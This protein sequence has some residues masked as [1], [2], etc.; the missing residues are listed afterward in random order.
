MYSENTNYQ[1]ELLDYVKSFPIFDAYNGKTL[2]ITGAAGLIGTYIVDLLMKKNEIDG[3]CITV[4]AIDR[5][6][7]EINSR[8]GMYF[9]DPNFKY[10]VLDVTQPMPNDLPRADY[11]IHAASNTSP[12]DYGLHPVDT[13]KANTVGT[14]YMLEFAHKKDVGRFLFCSSVEAY[15]K[16]LGDVEKFDE[17]YSGYVD[18]NTP[19]AAYPAGKRASEA[20][21]A[22]FKAEFGLDYVNARIGRFY[23]PTVIAGDTKAPTQFIMNGVRGEDILMKSDGTQIFSWGYV[24]D[25]ATGILYMLIKG[26][27]GQVYNI[28]DP[29][30]VL[31]LRDFAETVARIAG[32]RIVFTQQNAAELAGYSKITNA[33]LDTS[34][35]ESLGWTAKYD[36]AAGIEKTVRYLKTLV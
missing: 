30:S 22:S 1:S 5:N 14:Y 12:L 26:E 31:R 6:E 35:L 4:I 34:K 23:G 9:S 16:N 2:M 24:G 13:F 18:C 19:R 28:A 21:C 7:T 25:C 33:V 32:T 11:L 29:N 36:I 10:Y 20:M 27:S 3:S 15:G 17:S 8:F